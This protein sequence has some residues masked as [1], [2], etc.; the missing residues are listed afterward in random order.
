[1][2]ILV[3]G[4]DGQLGKAFQKKFQSLL[5]DN[6]SAFDIQYIGRRECDLADLSVLENILHEYQPNVI[7]NAAAYTAV[8]KAEQEIDLA[9]TINAAVPELLAK[10]AA[11]H[12]AY[13]LHYSTDY[14]FDGQGDAFYNEDHPIGPLSSY[15]KSKAEGERLI[16]EVF[17]SSRGPQISK[18]HYAIFRASWLYG[19]GDNF[20]R[21]ILR[22]AQDRSELKVIADQFG[23][24][25]STEWLVALSAD[26]LFDMSRAANIVLRDFPSG[27]YHAV[28]AGQTTWYG[29]ACLAVETAKASGRNLLLEVANIHAIPASEYPLPAPR[30]MNSRMSTQKL[31]KA[32]ADFGLV[33]QF[34]QWDQL[35]R[36]YV[37][38]LVK[39]QLI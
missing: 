10:Y 11:S 16:S 18:S 34:P 3:T 20:I 15:A 14:V 19:D 28:P 17:A 6:P 29:L 35:V 27:I 21:T 37:A 2:K 31:Q 39:N 7:I 1:M 38:D 8:D 13:L 32:L 36:I 12:G 24:P 5:Q 25:T 9:F 4:K 30:P 33:S 22:L 26:F 23:V